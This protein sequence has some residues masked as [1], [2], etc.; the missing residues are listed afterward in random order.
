MGSPPAVS[1]VIAAYNR[2][3]YIAAAVGS[4]LGQ[5]FSD[6]ELIVLDDGSSDRTV[7]VARKRAEGDSRVRV[8]EGPHR[9]VAATLN[10]AFRETRGK[11]FAWIDSD[12]AIA[13]TALAETAAYLDLHPPAEIVYTQYVTMDEDGTMRGLGTR[14]K[15]P[16]SKD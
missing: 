14:C 9:G 13:P 8:I 15:V 10:A 4:V 7:E 3:D 5:T 11:Y 1:I 12:D 16:Y 2:A 6:F